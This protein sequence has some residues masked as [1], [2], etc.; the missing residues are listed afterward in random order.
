MGHL[1]HSGITHGTLCT[2]PWDTA[3]TY[4]RYFRVVSTCNKITLECNRGV[5]RVL[6][7]C[8][9]SVPALL[10]GFILHEIDVRSILQYFRPYLRLKLHILSVTLLLQGCY[11][12]VPALLHGFIWREIDVTFITQYFRPNLRLKLHILSITLLL[13]ECLRLI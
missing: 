4:L 7:G 10:H 5:T 12:S 11:V 2:L 8:Q 6:Q 9:V 3:E 13:L 1:G